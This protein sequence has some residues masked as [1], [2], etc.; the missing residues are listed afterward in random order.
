MKKALIT[1]ITGQDGSYLAELLLERDYEVHGLVRRSSVVARDRIDHLHLDDSLAGRFFLHYGDLTDSTS[2]HHVVSSV[3]PDEVYNLAAQ[4]HVGVSFEMPEYTM[5]V[6]G[7]GIVRILEAIRSCGLADTCR[8]YQASTSEMFGLSAPPQR[9]STA[10]YPRSPY[11][12]AKL[13]AHWAV[14]NYRESYSMYAVSGILFNHESPRRAENF[15]TRKITSGVARIR[16][17]QASTLMLGN[18]DAVRDWGYAPEYVDGMWRM[19]QG[20]SP[21]DY[22]LATGVGTTVR[23]FCSTAFAAGGLSW[24]DHVLTS[25]DF[26]RPAEVPTLIGDAA[27]AG[28]ELGWKASVTSAE[29]ARLMVESDLAAAGL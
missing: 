20:T 11:G 24:Q 1:G 21:V 22:V 8:F 18:L 17:G 28:A 16:A 2:L 23:E 4:S 19:L 29:L 10:F 26:E 9:E 12:T 3:R 15:V 14:V 6:N 13:Q 25:T 7:Q 27:R 5:S